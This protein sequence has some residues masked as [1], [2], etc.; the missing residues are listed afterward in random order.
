MRT[1]VFIAGLVLCSASS[2]AVVAQDA[3]AR[4][5]VPGQAVGGVFFTLQ[6]SGK[7]A[8][9]EARCVCAEDVQIHETLD[10]NGVARMVQRERV[11]LSAGKRVRFKPGGL[12]VML[13]GLKAP[14]KAGQHLPLVLSVEEGGKTTQLNVDVVVRAMT[15][16][17]TGPE[18]H[19]HHHD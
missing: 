4:A 16:P 11:E 15:I 14:L 12:H 7:A 13:F 6:S 9:V 17:D 19:H 5:T 10:K 2:A 18:H 8:I 3:W 1:P